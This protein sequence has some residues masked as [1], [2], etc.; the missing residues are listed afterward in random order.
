MSQA[1][2]SSIKYLTFTLSSEL[3]AIEIDKVK[4][5]QDLVEITRIPQSPEFM[6]GVINLRGNAV[7]VFDLKSKFGLGHTEQTINTRVIILQFPGDEHQ[8]GMRADSVKEVIELEQSAVDPPPQMGT[9][10]QVNLL[11]GIARRG[12]RFLLLLDIEKA[13]KDDVACLPLGNSAPGAEADGE[14]VAVEGE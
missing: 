11:M 13:L 2:E 12:E 7:P 1:L 3:F 14:T 4:E 9:K 8:T 10:V 5:V 6:R